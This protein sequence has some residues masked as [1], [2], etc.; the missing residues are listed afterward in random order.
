MGLARQPALGPHLHLDR[1][2]HRLREAGRLRWTR[3]VRQANRHGQEPPT[4][5]RRA[6]AL[7]DE[8]AALAE[9]QGQPAR[10]LVAVDL[11]GPVRAQPVRRIHRQR[12]AAPRRVQGRTSVPGRRRLSG[13]EVRRAFLAAPTTAIRS[14]RRRSRPTGWM[15]WPP[16]RYSYRT[17]NYDIPHSGADSAIRGLMPKKER[18]AAYP[19]GADDPELHLGQLQLARHRRPGPRRAGAADLRLPDLGP[20][21]PD[22]DRGLGADR[23]HG[24]CDP[25]LFRRLDRP[26]LPALHR[27]MVVDAACSTSC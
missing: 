6:V 17:A 3:A 24:R 16:I 18:C 8:P 22:P 27:D 10:L 19:I 12:P 1:S 5:A 13:E 4:A 21:R 20:V 25:G 14:S 2:A 11:P 15:I 26:P 7:A 23:R 9:F